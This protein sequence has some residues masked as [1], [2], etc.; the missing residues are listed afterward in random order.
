MWREFWKQRRIILMKGWLIQ[1][2][3]VSWEY[4]GLKERRKDK[5]SI[6]WELG[7]GYASYP[8]K[9]FANVIYAN[10]KHVLA[11]IIF[12]SW[13][14]QLSKWWISSF[15]Y[16]YI[17]THT[18]THTHIYRTFLSKITKTTNKPTTVLKT[19]EISLHRPAQDCTRGQWSGRETVR[20][21]HAN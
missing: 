8:L 13:I 18:H 20:T 10:K 17:H 11:K 2:Q 6:R 14:H 4:T 21:L 3:N 16:I 7:E 19:Q 9:R 1:V 15:L 5:E 12:Y